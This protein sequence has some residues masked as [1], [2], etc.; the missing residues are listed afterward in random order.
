MY[1][2]F[3]LIPTDTKDIHGREIEAKERKH[4]IHGK[5]KVFSGYFYS[6]N[7]EYRWSLEDDRGESAP[8]DQILKALGFN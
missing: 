8:K 5:T 1:A 7:Y 6:G 2:D 4:P 3:Y